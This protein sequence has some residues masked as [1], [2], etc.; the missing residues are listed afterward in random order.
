MSRKKIPKTYITF[1]R[2]V[3]F[4]IY[5][6]LCDRW[7]FKKGFVPFFSG[8]KNV[9]FHC[10]PSLPWTKGLEN[11]F[12]ILAFFSRKIMA[13]LRACFTLFFL[14]GFFCEKLMVVHLID[15][16]SSASAWLEIFSKIGSEYFWGMEHLG[17]YFPG[18]KRKLK[19]SEMTRIRNYFIWKMTTLEFQDFIE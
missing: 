8:Q 11:D 19:N 5:L 16:R 14:T 2:C 7:C 6:F 10:D 12:V 18:K 13:G 17:V 4:R 1:E 3:S 9:G 15:I